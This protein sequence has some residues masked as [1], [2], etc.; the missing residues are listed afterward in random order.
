M[1]RT[2]KKLMI[3]FLISVLLCGCGRQKYNGEPLELWL[4]TEESRSGGMNTQAEMVIEQFKEIYPNVSVKMDIL[5]QSEESRTAYLKKIRSE[6]M[7]GGGPDL[8]LMPTYEL[9]YPETE[10][11]STDF[12]EPLFASVPKQMYNGVFTDIGEYYD[13]DETLGKDGLVTGVMD[14]GIMDGARYVMPLR[15][16][17][18]VLLA[19]VNAMEDLGIDPDLFDGGIDELYCLAERLQDDYVSF[20]LAAKPD[21]THASDYIDFQ[22][23]NVL[24]DASEF[25]SLVNGYYRTV[26]LA[27]PDEHQDQGEFFGGHYFVTKVGYEGYNCSISSYIANGNKKVA[28]F[29]TAGYPFMRVSMSQL[30][31]VAAAIKILDQNVTMH[32]I[33][34][35]DGRLIAEITY[36][37][38]VGS[39]CKYPEIA[40]EFLR[41]FYSEEL[42]WQQYY[43]WNAGEALEI[44][45][46]RGYPVRTVGFAEVQYENIRKELEQDQL[47]DK[48]MKNHTSMRRREPLLDKSFT[49]TDKDLPILATPVDEARFPFMTIDGE[50]FYQYVSKIETTEDAQAMMEDLKWLLAEG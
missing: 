45:A 17:Y 28:I 48:R 32:P 33:R 22:T 23:E 9:A 30:V 1:K 12:M 18:D 6:I 31:D 2:M 46:E 35:A 38:A 44:M 39:G 25:A 24:M 47:A 11:T 16:D 49:I 20:G 34:A 37:G 4:V 29:S 21:Y 15:Y 50:F 10:I 7:S 27:N 14:A 19:D 36:Y 3:L 41:T 13:A 43:P 8:Y 42:Q 26:E 40:Y 5:P